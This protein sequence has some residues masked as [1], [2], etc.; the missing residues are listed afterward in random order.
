MLNDPRIILSNFGIQEGTTV[1]DLGVGYGHT[2]FALSEKVGDSGKIF[3]IDIQ[4]N[5]LERLAKEATQKGIKN[6]E[7]IWGDIETT[8]GT[9]LR[10]ASVDTCV[11]SNVLFQVESKA[12][13][14]NECARILK[15]GGRVLLIDWYESFGGLGPQPEAVVDEETARKIFETGPFQFIKSLPAGDHHYALVFERRNS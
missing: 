10:E 15:I 7:I 1:A 9:K 3:A 14:V 2:A 13:L 4:K 6:I 11:I 12:G 5:L 8:G